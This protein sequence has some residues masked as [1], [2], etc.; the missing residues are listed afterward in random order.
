MSILKLKPALKQTIWGGQRLKEFYGGEA[1]DNIA[2][3]WVLSCHPDGESLVIGGSFDGKTLSQALAAMGDNALGENCAGLRDFPVLIKF[4][5]AADKLSVQVHPD[6]E[7][8]RIHENENGK[9]EAWYIMDAETDSR[10]I[11]G[12]KENM[13]REEFSQSIQ[14]GSLLD[15]VNNV[16]VK[17]GDIAFIPSG[18]LHAIGEGILLCEVQQSSNTTYRVFD[19]NRL[20]NGKPREL[21]IKQAAEV[22]ACEKTLPDFSPCEGK[23]S[24][25]EYSTRLLCECQYFRMTGIEVTGAAELL[26]DKKSFVSLVV[27]EGRGRLSLG[28]ETAELSKGDSIFIPADSGKFTIEGNIKL[29]ETRV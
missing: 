2:E 4:I 3:A 23:I 8:A 25:R 15:K 5:D 19:Y 27:L 9:T 13:T 21:H 29:L 1:M 16:G 14:D 10:L 7:Y 28:S 22:V 20:Q 11:Y 18:T 26:A 17:K 24:Y 6:D 12:L